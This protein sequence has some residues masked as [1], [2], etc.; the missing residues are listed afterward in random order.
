M[1]GAGSATIDGR[2]FEWARGDALAV[3][4]SSSHSWTAKEESYLLRVSDKPLLERLDW[5]R[6]VPA[7]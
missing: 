3:P 2:T 1:K 4:S 5:L 7:R 6:P